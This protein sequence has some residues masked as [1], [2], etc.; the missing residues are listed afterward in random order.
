MAR[1]QN[2]APSRREI[3]DQMDVADEAPRRGP[4][5]AAIP[6]TCSSARGVV[7]GSIKRL[8]QKML[9]EQGARPGRSHDIVT[10]ASHQPMYYFRCI[11][12]EDEC[13]GDPHAYPCIDWRAGDRCRYWC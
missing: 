11:D 9:P 7:I 12:A 4:C 2:T 6:W 13:A 8:I 1:R 10:P 3:A 5:P